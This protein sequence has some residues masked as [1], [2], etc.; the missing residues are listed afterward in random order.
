MIA[1]AKRV[2][3]IFLGNVNELPKCWKF[4]EKVGFFSDKASPKNQID[5]KNNVRGDIS[6]S[7]TPTVGKAL[8]KATGC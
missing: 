8:H 7:Q 5:Q 6:C 1:N 4:H 2:M 3:G